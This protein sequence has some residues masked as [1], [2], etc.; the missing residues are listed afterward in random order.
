[1]DD[2][3]LKQEVVH[4]TKDLT[5]KKGKAK[6]T[7]PLQDKTAKGVKNL[8]EGEIIVSFVCRKEGKWQGEKQN[9]IIK[10]SNTYNI[11]CKNVYHPLSCEEEE[12]WQGDIH[13]IDSKQAKTKRSQMDLGA[14]EIMSII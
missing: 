5:K 9:P 12:K 3:H 6:P 1:M 8:D 14:K 7:Q 11:R 13:Q 10:L 4:H 2:D